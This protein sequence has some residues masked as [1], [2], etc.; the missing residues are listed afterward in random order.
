MSIL[1]LDLEYIKS[2]RVELGV[3]SQTMA[4]ELGFK[5]A[6]TYWKYENGEYK[7]RADMLPKIAKI[8]KCRIENFFAN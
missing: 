5:D 8:L 3:S 4:D 1:K 6:S 2:R 7:L